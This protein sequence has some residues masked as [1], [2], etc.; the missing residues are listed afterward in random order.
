MF[1]FFGQDL[2][3]LTDSDRKKVLDFYHRSSLTSYCSAF[4]YVP[5]NSMQEN[6]SLNDC[7]I[8][9]PPD[10]SHLF[11]SQKS[12]DSSLRSSEHHN[13]LKVLN[14]TSTKSAIHSH[15]LS[16]D[17]LVKQEVFDLNRTNRPKSSASASSSDG[18][19][20]EYLMHQMS[21]EIFIGMTTMQY[22]AC[23]D[24]VHLVEQ[25]ET[26]IRISNTSHKI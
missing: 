20:I 17:S 18:H 6:V 12:L 13:H 7:Y 10:S 26:G 15:H 5:L 1:T 2:C 19:Q 16:S 24:F 9:L 11:P 21:N 8:E 14:D 3:V 23:S 22:Q 25:L 4:A